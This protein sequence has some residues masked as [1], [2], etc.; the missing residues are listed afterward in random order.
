MQQCT[1]AACCLLSTQG[2]VENVM[3]IVMVIAA[4]DTTRRSAQDD[5]TNDSFAKAT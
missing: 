3:A 1:H 4:T 5:T 2:L